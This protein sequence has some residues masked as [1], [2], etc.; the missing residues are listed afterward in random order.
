MAFKKVSNLTKQVTVNFTTP[1]EDGQ[2]EVKQSF[3]VCWKVPRPARMQAA[4]D[5]NERMVDVLYEHLQWLDLEGGDNTRLS[6]GESLQA[7]KV[8]EGFDDPFL[9]AA[10]MAA[11]LDASPQLDQFRGKSKANR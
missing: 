1:G 8:V 5:S 9:N 2:G 11:F 6:G 3:E 7:R 10:L 4:I